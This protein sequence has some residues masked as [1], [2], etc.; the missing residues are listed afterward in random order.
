MKRHQSQDREPMI[1][2][3]ESSF[4]LLRQATPDFLFGNDAGAVDLTQVK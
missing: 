1:I 3:Q 4:D 2:F